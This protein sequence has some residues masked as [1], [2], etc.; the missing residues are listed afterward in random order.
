MHNLD[1]HLIKLYAF[2][3]VLV[4]PLFSNQ[5]NKNF[6]LNGTIQKNTAAIC[7]SS[8][9]TETKQSFVR[10]LCHTFASILMTQKYFTYDHQRQVRH[11]GMVESV[12][13]ALV[14]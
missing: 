4:I 2:S 6:V 3:S 11:A 10:K 14:T 7:L 8:I 1:C 5:S 13:I 9:M 12:K